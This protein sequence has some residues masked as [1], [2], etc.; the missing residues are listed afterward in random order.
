MSNT[1]N[2]STSVLAR[3]AAQ[4]GIEPNKLY[5]ALA[6]VAFRQKTAP[7]TEEMLALCLVANRYGLDPF[8]KQIHAFRSKDGLLVPVVGIDGWLAI[9]N[10]QPSFD[11]LEV[12]YAANAVVC[13]GVELPEWVECVIY[14]KDITRSIKIKEFAQECFVAS[15]SVWHRFGR[16]MLRHKAIIQAARVAFGISGIYDEDEALDQGVVCD[17]EPAVKGAALPNVEQT[18]AVPKLAL[19]QEQLDPLLGQ[20]VKA[21][22]KRGAWDVAQTWVQEKLEEPQRSYAAQF[23]E[24]AK[25]MQGKA[26][27]DAESAANAPDAAP[28]LE[29][30]PQSAEIGREPSDEPS[31]ERLQREERPEDATQT[32]AA[33]VVQT[34]MP[35]APP[36]SVF[37]PF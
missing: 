31:T 24:N 4:Y 25:A 6:K 27:A 13:D 37:D 18:K 33:P 29:A 35:P 26:A 32:C 20:L 34:P 3:M 22:V 23:L 10:R 1:V 2:T 7:S 12:N 15:S 9:I 5:A 36:A 14:R 19:S 21:A 17:A 8:A 16:R 11:G 28:S 30:A